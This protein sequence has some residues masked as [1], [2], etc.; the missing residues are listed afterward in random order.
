MKKLESKTAFHLFKPEATVFVVAYDSVLQ[1]PTGMVAGYNMKCSSN[2]SMLAVALWIEGYTHK[3]IQREKE[4]VIAVPSKAMEK[5]ISVF[6]KL[7]GN[8]VDKFVKT[9]IP[10]KKAEFVKAPLLEEAYLNFECKLVKEV[11][12]GDHILFIGEVLQA[13]QNEDNGVIL[14]M[15]RKDGERVFKEFYPTRL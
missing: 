2:P 11:E 8:D 10:T 14:N 13:Y 4:F 15:G 9:N 3:V 6:G 12:S 1:R 5:Y 7:H